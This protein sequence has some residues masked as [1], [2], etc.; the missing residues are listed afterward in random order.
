[1]RRF[2]GLPGLLAGTRQPFDLRHHEL[3]DLRRW[4]DGLPDDD[5]SWEMAFTEQLRAEEG[6]EAAPE[7]EP[8][9]PYPLWPEPGGIFPWAEGSREAFF[10]LRSVPEPASWPVVWWH[11]DDLEWERFDGTATEFLIALV[12]GQ[13]EARRLGSPSFPPPPRFDM[14][15]AGEPRPT[16]GATSKE[17]IE[18]IR[19]WVKAHV[20]DIDPSSGE[21]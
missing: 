5:E 2:P 15:V 6:L 11:G 14:A 17:E 16:A 7:P 1:V 21:A 12:T 9:F 3:G 4:R 13:I 8:S 19:A 20:R 10:W 18:Q